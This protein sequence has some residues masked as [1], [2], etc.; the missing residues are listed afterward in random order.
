MKSKKV[1][2]TE[3]LDTLKITYP[4]VKCELVHST[5]LE[6]LIATILSAQC[7]DKQ[8]NKVTPKL[9]ERFPLAQDYALAETTEIAGYITSIG[10]YRA[11]SKHIKQCCEQIVLKH[12]GNVPSTMESLLCLAGV[13]RKTANVVLGNGFGLN[14]GIVVDTH[15]ARVSRRLGLTSS[16]KP[17]QIE[18]D[19]LKKVPQLEW[20]DF[21]HRV[22]SHG[23]SLCKAR[24][25]ACDLCP[26]KDLCR[27]YKTSS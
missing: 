5:P 7:S 17:V 14:V 24:N 15:V 20:T 23:R 19:L 11:K 1:S 22:I 9:F 12:Q 8:V 4:E 26:M 25:P 2:S 10:L 3:I 27:Y 6:L 16:T 21:S 18:M 13:G